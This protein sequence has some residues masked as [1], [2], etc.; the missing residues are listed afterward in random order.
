MSVI[1]SA[2]RPSFAAA[3]HG[4]PMNASC[5]ALFQV[6][7]VQ[8]MCSEQ[9]LS[10]VHIARTE[11]NWPKPVDPVTSSVN[12]SCA[13]SSVTS[14]R[15]TLYW[16]VA[17]F[18]TL[19]RATWTL[20]LVFTC[21]EL[22]FSSIHVMWTRLHSAAAAAAA[23]DA[24]RW[25]V[26]SANNGMNTHAPTTEHE[27]TTAVT[28]L[29]DN[30][31]HDGRVGTRCKAKPGCSP[32]GYPPRRLLIIVDWSINWF[33]CVQRSTCT[34]C[35]IQS[36]ASI[37]E[38]SEGEMLR[39]NARSQGVNVRSPVYRCCRQKSSTVDLVYYTYDGRARRG[40]LHKAYYT[41]VTV[42]K[43]CVD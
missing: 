25:A 16:L 15:P 43:N 1:F 22:R 23:A 40:W 38:M 32:P 6:S 33:V 37:R 34:S 36:H 21:S 24:A 8:F 42:T 7:S 31:R 35:C 2:P 10:L 30:R 28:P 18:E 29:T 20:P 12:W 26:T 17:E 11:L 14:H 27:T 39:G 4:W 9:T 5:V 19:V 13:Q 3:N 41:L